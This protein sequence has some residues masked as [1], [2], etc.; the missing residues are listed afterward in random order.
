MNHVQPKSLAFYGSAI[1][2]VVGLFAVVT[3]YGEANLKTAQSI[4]G[5][6]L[7]NLPAASACGGGKPV[8]LSIQQSGMYVAAAVTNPALTRKSPTFKPMTLSGQWKNQQI[9]LE[10][11]IPA[12]VLCDRSKE[13][14]SAITVKIEGAISQ[15]QPPAQAMILTGTLSL[16]ASAVPFIAQRQPIPKDEVK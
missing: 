3:A 10:G 6:Y 4:G 12:G 14:T 15:N 9:T 13:A 11:Q 5:D 7:F 8:L 2:F 1:A 16:N